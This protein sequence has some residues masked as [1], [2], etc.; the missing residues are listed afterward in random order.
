MRLEYEY[1]FHSDKEYARL[2]LLR[3][4]SSEVLVS[5]LGH[6]GQFLRY[7][8]EY[9]LLILVAFL[10]NMSLSEKEEYLEILILVA[11]LNQ[12]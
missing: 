10:E 6:Q 9:Q 11:F 7:E 8:I 3:Q 2:F 1:Q 12:N 4:F 5:S